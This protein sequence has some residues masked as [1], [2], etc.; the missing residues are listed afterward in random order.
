MALAV[1]SPSNAVPNLIRLL[2]DP[3]TPTN[4]H[5]CLQEPDDIMYLPSL[6]WHM[7]INIGEVRRIDRAA[8]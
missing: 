5:V 6:W 4:L 8:T 7:T 1:K 2:R 3:R